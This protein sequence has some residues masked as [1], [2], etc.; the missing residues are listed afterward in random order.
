M[1]IQCDVGGDWRK[2]EGVV[3]RY[4]WIDCVECVCVWE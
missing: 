2:E 1:Y 3:W 4:W